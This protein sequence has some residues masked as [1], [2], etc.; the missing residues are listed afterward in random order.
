MAYKIKKLS[1][2]RC[3]VLSLIAIF[4][5]LCTSSSFAQ[6][7]NFYRYVNKDGVKVIT[8]SIPPEYAQKGYEVITRNGQVIKVVAAAEDPAKLQA[9]LEERALLAKYEILARRYSSIEDIYSARDRRLANLDA[10]ISI[11][12]NNI[13]NLKSQIVDLM[14][15]AAEAERSGREVSPAIL[16]NIEEIKAEV[17]TS[18]ANLKTREDEHKSISNDYEQ[19]VALFKKGQLLMESLPEMPPQAEKTP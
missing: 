12:K 4:L 16:K 17:A 18:E 15:K 1:Y 6:Q 5:G 19:D 8:N 9:K 2:F 11:Q 7:M 13:G 14:G 10:T 3:S